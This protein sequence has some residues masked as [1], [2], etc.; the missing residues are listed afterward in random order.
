MARAKKNDAIT[1]WDVSEKIGDTVW[2]MQNDRVV[3]VV[4]GGR[5]VRV[6]ESDGT[7]LTAN[8]PIDFADVLWQDK[9]LATIQKVRATS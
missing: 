9:V 7:W 1:I 3:A 2:L 8:E 6:R 4:N 5:I